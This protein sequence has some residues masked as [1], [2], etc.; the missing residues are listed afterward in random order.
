MRPFSGA[1]RSRGQYRKTTSASASSCDARTSTGSG[2]AGSGDAPTPSD[3]EY[4]RVPELIGVACVDMSL[5]ASDSDLRAQVRPAER[6]SNPLMRLVT[7]TLHGQQPAQ[8]SQ[9]KSGQAN[10]RPTGRR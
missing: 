5:I 3:D 4:Y 6:G 7:P 2:E 9:V 8:S 10:S 1:S